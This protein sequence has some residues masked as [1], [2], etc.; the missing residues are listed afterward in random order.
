[1][2]E[3]RALQ[4]SRTDVDADEVEK[5]VRAEGLDLGNG[6]ALD[7]VGQERCARLADRAAAA[8]EA[9]P[10]DDPVADPELH[11]DPVTAQGVAALERRGRIVDD[12]EVVGPPVVLED[13][14][15][16]E[17]VHARPSVART[18]NSDHIGRIWMRA[19]T[20]A[21]RRVVPPAWS[22]WPR[23]AVSSMRHG[24]D[25]RQAASLSGRRSGIATRPDPAR[26]VR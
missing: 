19:R 22:N 24:I 20:V 25:D 1:M 10:L 2:A 6:L 7:L 3:H 18:R 14:V 15:A 5:V 8:G 17:V 16:V 12:P 13:V 26:P 23:T 21:P 4:A 9:D 11:R